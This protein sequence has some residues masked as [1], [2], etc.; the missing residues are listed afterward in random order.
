M[1]IVVVYIDIG[2]QANHLKKQKDLFLNGLED[3]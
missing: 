3:E 2:L 1:I